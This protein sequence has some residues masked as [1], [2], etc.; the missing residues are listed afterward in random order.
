MWNCYL[1]IFEINLQLKCF[2]GLK[3]FF[4][5]FSPPPSPFIYLLGFGEVLSIR[6]DDNELDGPMTLL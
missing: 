4:K 2:S 6:V 3:D 1:G 5:C